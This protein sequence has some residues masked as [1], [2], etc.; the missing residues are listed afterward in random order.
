MRSTHFVGNF[1]ADPSLTSSKCFAFLGCQ[2]SWP[3]SSGLPMLRTI[4]FL[5]EFIVR[6]QF[7]LPRLFAFEPFFFVFYATPWSIPI[8]FFCRHIV[9]DITPAPITKKRESGA[10]FDPGGGTVC[11]GYSEDGAVEFGK[12]HIK[13][14]KHLRSRSKR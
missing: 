6:N 5:K 12:G 8:F 2:G 1:L 7:S 13:K 10:G 11:T 4:D 9:E 14:F 3:L